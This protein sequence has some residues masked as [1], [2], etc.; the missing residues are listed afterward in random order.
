MK[1]KLATEKNTESSTLS[2]REDIASF[3]IHKTE[4]IKPAPFLITGVHS[5]LTEL[6][7]KNTFGLHKERI[8]I[9]TRY[10]NY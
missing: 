4:L 6:Y 3:L 8:C 5:E 7:F 9:N 10:Y 2:K 1:A